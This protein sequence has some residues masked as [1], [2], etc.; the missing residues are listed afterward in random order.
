LTLAAFF[1]MDW[2][3]PCNY[4]SRNLSLYVGV[5][6]GRD[7]FERSVVGGV[8]GDGTGDFV[9]GYK[10]GVIRG[11]V[12]GAGLG[13]C[14]GEPAAGLWMLFSGHACTRKAKVRS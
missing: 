13:V 1:A 8:V 4:T 11:G 12:K 2:F 14:L 10:G 7:S 9:E 3:Q 5:I 6:V